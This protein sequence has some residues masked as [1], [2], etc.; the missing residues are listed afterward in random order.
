[1][2]KETL[3]ELPL[4]WYYIKQGK[5]S[6]FSDKKVK[7][8]SAVNPY[9]KK[10]KQGATL[11]PRT[12]YFVDVD[13]AYP[14]GWEKDFDWSDRIIKLKTA[15]HVKTDA[16]APWKDLK[17]S[18]KMNSQFIFRTALSK[19]I[20]PFALYKPDLVVLP[21]S[22]EKKANIKYVKLLTPPEIKREGYLLASKWFTNAENIWNIHKTEKNK[23][24]LSGDYLNWQGKL[25]NQNLNSKYLVIYNSSAKDANATIVERKKLDLEF[26]VESTAYA[27]YTDNKKEAFYLTT[28][29]N[30]SI[31]NQ[32]MK[33]F[34]ARGLFG[35][36]HV[37]KKILDVYFPKYDS[38][39]ELHNQLAALGAEAHKKASEYIVANPPQQELS[40]MHLGRLRLAIKKHLAPEMLN[41]DN[42]VKKIIA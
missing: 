37:H 21:I 23:N 19:N 4:Q 31:P 38:S 40:G 14:Q 5:S 8:K 42:I 7:T 3:T 27:F 20:L 36:R 33:A 39:N 29:L 25:I 1:M 22:I 18:D 17:F 28:I 6:A 16:K 32:M 26:I 35:A 10:F 2:A 34:Q 15:E 30:S 13:M 41:I 9:S 12:L 11:V 24:I